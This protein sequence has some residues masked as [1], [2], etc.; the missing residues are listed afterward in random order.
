MVTLAKGWCWEVLKK[1]YKFTRCW[2]TCHLS[3]ALDDSH[4]HGFPLEGVQQ[5]PGVKPALILQP[6]IGEPVGM[7][8][9][10]QRKRKRTTKFT[11]VWSCSPMCFTTAVGCSV[12]KLTIWSQRHTFCINPGKLLLQ[13]CGGQERNL[14]SI[15]PA[16]QSKHDFVFFRCCPKWG[17]DVFFF[18][19]LFNLKFTNHLKTF[20]FCSSP[21]WCEQHSHWPGRGI[22]SGWTGRPP[23]LRSPRQGDPGGGRQVADRLAVHWFIIVS[24]VNVKNIR[25][26][27]SWSWQR[28]V[29]GRC[30]RG[31]RTAA[32]SPQLTA[33]WSS[34]STE[35]TRNREQEMRQDC[36]KRVCWKLCCVFQS[37]YEKSTEL[38]RQNCHVLD[39]SDS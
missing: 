23:G 8:L 9:Q 31:E 22:L 33:R 28:P 29:R 14:G 21:P 5:S 27:S 7:N 13:L 15:T 38:D 4:R 16:K 12:H 20:G 11:C 3:V 2:Q 36:T 25:W 10:K 32:G 6:W 26:C 17:A 18:F 30:F 39:V 19:S 35:E 1:K 37:R 24:S 34:A